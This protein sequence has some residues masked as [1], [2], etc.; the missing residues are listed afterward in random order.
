MSEKVFNDRYALKDE[1]GNQIEHTAEEMWQRVARAM[2]GQ[3][4]DS[5]KQKEWEEKFYWALEDFKFV[6]GGRILSGA[7]S[8][9]QVTYYNCYV[10]PSPSDSRGGIMDSV[11]NMV[12]IMARG[13]GVGV[14]L[15]TLRPRGAH[16][17]GVNGKASGAV[18]FGSLYSYATGLVIQGGSRRGALMLMLDDD[19]PDV[20]EFITVKRTMG[21]V[22]NAN[23]SVCI[24]DAFMQAVKEDADW[25]LKW[26]GKVY[27]TIKARDLWDLITES[28]HLSGEPGCVFMERCQKQS[29][30]WYFEHINCVNP[31]GEQPLPGW[32]VCN[33]GS[34]NL[35]PFAKEDQTVDYENL[36]KTIRYATRLMDNVIDATPYAFEENR[37]A[38]LNVRRVGLGTMGLADFLIKL[39][40]RYGSDEAIALTEEVYQFIQN[41]TYKA[42]IEIAKEKGVFPDFDAEKFSQGYHIKKL[43]HDI[44]E[45]IHRY[46]IRNGVLQT[47][48][49][50][51]TTSMLAGV[52][53]GIEPVFDFAFKRTDRLGEHLIYHPL[54]KEWKDNHPEEKDPDYFVN[55]KQLTPLEHV[56][57]QAVA[58]KYTDASISKTVNAPENHTHE[59]VK[60]L[61][62]KAYDLGCKGV[63]YYRENSRDISVLESLD[64]VKKKDKKSTGKLVQEQSGSYE[65]KSIDKREVEQGVQ[66]VVPRDRPEV[67]QGK[68][69]KVNTSYG[70]LFVTVNDSDDGKPFE[71]FATIGKAG[72]FFAAKSEAICR[73]ASLA[74]RAGVSVDEVIKQLK[75]IR[76]PMPSFNGGGIKIL[77]LADA[78]AHILERHISGNQAQ[79]DLGIASKAEQV[80][81]EPVAV[82]NSEQI[83]QSIA[84][85]G[86]APECPTCGGV[87][88]M[89]EGCMLCRGCGFSRCG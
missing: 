15:S 37:T 84:D 21:Q 6:P 40:V 13:G 66:E 7:G 42:S 73:L 52:S 41:E 70:K 36:G 83:K 71:V 62:I 45:D 60:E 78:I 31:C 25:D 61:Y 85:N 11:K 34:V 32:G 9:A 54:Y 57:M 23:L 3:E 81:H 86:Y 72:G 64:S 28:A 39:K 20:E 87:L 17:K 2:A 29:N 44:Q 82:S 49:P 51:G 12:E 30:T 35:V 75:G 89:G 65:Y 56:K 26:G 8:A 27:K 43:P 77:S 79:L 80:N 69:Y 58:Q 50:T 55:A 68:T 88:E 10:L 76:G 5:T 47:Q 1:A 67:M 4:I 63:T 53:S 38:Q 19:H 48:A 24:S 14:N 33:L 46:G 74:L 59:D 18:S 16:V 22:T